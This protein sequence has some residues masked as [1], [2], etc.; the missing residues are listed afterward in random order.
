M[1]LINPVQSRAVSPCESPGFAV[2]ALTMAAEQWPSFDPGRGCRSP[3]PAPPGARV[4]LPWFSLAK[5]LKPVALLGPRFQQMP[6][7]A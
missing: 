4:R 3:A 7:I 2:W 5:A 1:L 6:F